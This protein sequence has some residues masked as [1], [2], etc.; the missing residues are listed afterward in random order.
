MSQITVRRA[1]ANDAAAYAR[2]MSHPEVQPSLLQVPFTDEA[3]WR[4][5]LGEEFA[6]GSGHLPLA[7]EIGG[8][9]V[10]TAGLH[11]VGASL[12]RRHAMALGIAIAPE[13][14]GRGV[15]RALMQAMCDYADHW[16]QVLRLELT[17]FHDNARAIALYRRF[18]F[19]EE[20][21]HRGYGLRHGRYV[22]ALTMARWHPSPQALQPQT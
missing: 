12:R 21:R 3:L 20:G 4:Q 17:V 18:G 22:D 7:A 6:P 10:G 14:Q 8:V 19:E 13:A 11:P 5:R 9:V 16:T 15:G 1:N 2:I